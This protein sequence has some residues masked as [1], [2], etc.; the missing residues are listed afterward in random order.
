M[1]WNKLPDSLLL[2]NI[3]YTFDALITVDRSIPFQQRLNN[4]PF[5]VIVLR[6]KTNRLADLLPLVPA[7]LRAL[8]E[9]KPGEVREVRA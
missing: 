3:S 6:A 4:R 9:I 2:G 8:D 5:A 7:L 1:G